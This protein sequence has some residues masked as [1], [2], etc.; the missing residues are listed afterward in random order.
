MRDKGFIF[1]KL[2]V[3]S[4]IEIPSERVSSW[5]KLLENLI[6]ALYLN[7]YLFFYI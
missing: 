5:R 7:N 4:V 3:V 1:L 6:I 2:E